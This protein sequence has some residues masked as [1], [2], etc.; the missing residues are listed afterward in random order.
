LKRSIFH[1][2]SSVLWV[3]IVTAIVLLAVYVSTGRMLSALSGTYQ[4]EILQGLNQRLPLLIDA[5]QV[6]AQWQ[7][8]S[9][10]LVFDELR[11]TL[12]G[13]RRHSLEV[14]QGRI[15]LDVAASLRTRSMQISLLSLDGLGL[16]GSLDSDGRLR[17][18]GFEGSEVAPGA[19]QEELL[20]NVERVALGDA[21][22][23]LTMPSGEQ[24]EFGLDLALSR[25]GSHR[26][27]EGRLSSSRG[28]E[29]T[30]L[31]EGVGNPFEPASFNGQ[32]Y[33]N[34]AAADV[35]AL[36]EFR[37]GALSELQVGGRLDLELWTS[38]HKGEPVTALRVAV[39]DLLLQARDRSWQLALDSMGFDASV[40]SH[41]DGWSLSVAA[42]EA[43]RGEVLFKLPRL[44]LDLRGETMDLRALDL[45]LAPLGGLLAGSDVL[46]AALTDLV[47]VLQ[48]RGLVPALQL[49]VASIS[50][51]LARWQLLAAFDELAVEPWHGAPGISG[52]RGFVRLA[53]GSGAV[54]LDSSQFSMFFPTVYERALEYDDFH[55]TINIDWD[56]ESVA[57]SSGLLQAR[58]EEGPVRVLFGL[59]IPLLASEVGLEM[60]LLVGLENTRAVHR[61]KYIPYILSQELRPWL[62]AS[63]G[64]GMIEQGGFIWR[65]SLT[66]QSTAL[67]TVQL[68]FNVRDTALSFHPDWPALAG[69]DGIV[70]IDDSNVSVWA[71]TAQLLDSRVSDLSVEVW[72]DAAS[73][74]WLAVDGSVVGP[75]A[76]GLAVVNESPLADLAGDVFAHWQLGGDLATDI[77]LRL[78]LGEG[79]A[80]PEVR[81]STRLRDV[82]LDIRP[83]GLAVRAISGVLDYDTRTG[84]SSRDLAGQLWGQ[85]LQ[86]SV[87]QA[88]AATPA[89][90]AAGAG[91]AG[92]GP[93]V[94]VAMQTTV[95]MADLGQ[96]LGVEQAGFAEGQ[97]AVNLELRAAA[98]AAPML[99][100]D[101]TLAGVSL[102]LPAPWDKAA[103]TQRPLHLE[104]ALGRDSML[105]DIA[106]ADTLAAELELVEGQLRAGSVA[107]GSQPLGLQPGQVRVSGR[108]ALLDTRQWQDF[109][110]AHVALAPAPAPAQQGE[111][112][113]QLA[114]SVEGLQVDRLVFGGREFAGVLLAAEGDGQRWRITASTDWLRGELLYSPGT[115]SRLD[116][117]HLD[118]A[119]LDSPDEAPVAEPRIIEVPDLAVTIGELR[120]GESV[121][122]KLAFDL[123]SD[124]AD[125]S[126][127]N[128]SGDFLALQLR[129]EDPGELVWHQG[130][131][132]RSVLNTRLFFQDLGETLEALGYEKAIFTREG[133]FDLALE[134]PGGPQ[135]FSLA[136]GQGSLAVDIEEGHFPDVPVGAAGALR[137]ISILNLAEI[138]RRLS[139]SQMFESGIAFDK[140]D[141]EASLADGSIA[142]A[143]MEVQGGASAFHF[144]GVSKVASRAVEGELVVTLPVA[145]NLPWVA[146][147]TAGLPVAAGVFLLSKV[148]ES[149]VNRL[150]SLVYAVGGSWDDPLVKFDR[151][152]DDTPSPEDGAGAPAAASPAAPAQSGSP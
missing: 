20:L 89:G 120:R 94:S 32:L 66:A 140:V 41:A 85:A 67:H 49:E 3:A 25:E 152:F 9:P 11:L 99:S 106:V 72:S 33:L 24:R 68:F 6:S 150:T 21:R 121:L 143:S 132:S 129:A 127:R 147:L 101:S 36:A 83:G 145:N 77:A 92:E 58:G 80:P 93:A 111:Q 105:L 71:D 7:A 69:I 138:V 124:G 112:G 146:A 18:S 61:G 26:R 34:V 60:D 52:A 59:S 5:Q 148:F 136:S 14:S 98:G 75:A 65:G 51:P 23:A 54:V 116:I 122:G 43:A 48:P 13:A 15:A 125:L 130:A 79:A 109:L 31:A 91:A 134:W 38:W 87:G 103:D 2:L 110:E 17:I 56:A 12:P 108:T 22:L 84:F 142:V 70:L 47:G 126:A 44:Q 104:L 141:G 64:D 137:V 100:I 114:F 16:A 39:D 27:L 135:D 29:L 131:D 128:I 118:L 30:A 78:D 57:L 8:F 90:A 42:L 102:D 35:A 45:P 28:M 62:A 95:A 82:D 96:W 86:V 115:R 46:S 81:V 107:L 50:D 1:R 151:V 119:G 149:Q 73:E 97:T 139:L 144:S 37:A 53:P 40:D 76:D 19:W 55:G 117:S 63:I 88:E 113:P 123:Q 10:V 74:L 4:S 133:S